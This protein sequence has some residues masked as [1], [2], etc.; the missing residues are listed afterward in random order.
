MEKEKFVCDKC[1]SLKEIIA[2]ID[3]FQE[4]HLLERIELAMLLA[5]ATGDVSVSTMSE[6]LDKE[7]DIEFPICEEDPSCIDTEIVYAIAEQVGK[8]IVESIYGIDF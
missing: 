4:L 6:C 2:E 1:I 8:E 5:A 7:Q 3:P